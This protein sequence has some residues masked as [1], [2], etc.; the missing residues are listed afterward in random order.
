LAGLT[1]AP[2]E[3]DVPT[4]AGWPG[5]LARALAV[6]LSLYALYWVV[7]IVEPRLYRV[8][9]LLLAL[10]LTFL[11]VPGRALRVPGCGALR[12][13]V[14]VDDRAAPDEPP[15]PRDETLRSAR[16]TPMRPGV[17]GGVLAAVSATVLAWP[18]VDR[19][20]FPYRAVT[21][22][23]TDL[24]CGGLAI[25]LVLEA[26]R[27]TAG[28]ALPVTAAAFVAYAYLGPLF[29]LVGLSALA[30]RGYY[31]D[32]L[33]GTLFMT[34]DGL[35]GVPLEVAA[36]Y[37]ILF[38][39]YGAVL[40]HSGAGPFFIDWSMAAL[41]RSRSAAAPARSV[42]L[43]GFLLG[44]VSGSG[45][46][47]TVTLGPL[48]WPLLRRAGYSPH[49]GGAVLAAAGIGALL[50]PPTMGA[51]AFLIAEFLEVSYLQVLVMAALPT[52]LYY[53]SAFLMVESDARKLGARDAPMPAQALGP[54]TRRR[55]YHFVSL[56]LV[57]VLMAL[58]LT[59]FRAV[60]WSIVV[61]VASSFL[62]PETAL[63]PRRLL[64]ALEAGGR[65]AVM[66]APTTAVAGIVVGVV[67]L[68]GLGLKL[69]GLMVTLAGGS[70]LGTVLLG[71][72]AVWLLGLAMPVTASYIMGAVMIVP[73]LTQVGVPA[74]AAHMF[75]FYYAVLSE[76]S[77]PTALAP[78]AAAAITGGEP[79]RTTLLTWKYALPAFLVPITF[80]LA[81]AGSALLLRAPPVEVLRV[82]SAAALG[83]AALTV[84]LGGWLWGPVPRSL[85]VLAGVS[86]L[87]LFHPTAAPEAAGL[88]VAAVVCGSRLIGRARAR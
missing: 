58:G 2:A 48:A 40:E 47:T 63:W 22:T 19:A 64:A 68:T 27:R 15:R 60:A 43:A 70:T 14:S 86:G 7:A 55:G 38:S 65:A 24:V 9:F 54:L 10:V 32:R 6:A 62:R 57:A 83:V 69:S 85:R 67:G 53:L 36:T 78:F 11:A 25:L 46:A 16:R 3:E 72:L 17:V 79:L 88:A 74:A 52:A 44:T 37:I 31:P 59:A 4:P 75:V 51:A 50:S 80:T 8:S 29:D 39:I 73:A 28:W 77:P 71:A 87:L 56:V 45:V 41:G 26:A 34:L 23:A 1:T 76:V 82:F 13:A 81:P 35:F 49:A 12:S 5:P 84:A 30:H 66:I 42:T 33:I 61:A 18:L 21:P 20:E